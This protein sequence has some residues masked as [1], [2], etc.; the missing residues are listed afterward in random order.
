MSE[1]V[2]YN[3]RTVTLPPGCKNLIDVLRAETGRQVGSV[4]DADP[5]GENSC[6]CVGKDKLA[7]IGKYVGMAF[8]SRAN[9]VMLNVSSPDST[10]TFDLVRMLDRDMDASVAVE[11]GTPQEAAVRKFF[12][13]HRLRLP[14]DPAVSQAFFPEL[15]VKV[16]YS[17]SPLPTEPRVLSM[18]AAAM[19]REVCGLDDESVLRFDFCEHS[20]LKGKT[21]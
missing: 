18:L 1:F 12:A 20:T 13:Q 10:I 8:E 6:C 11:R 5:I 3:K 14:A 7:E 21:L 4:F 2:N 9:A 17:I 19:F 16:I 15:P